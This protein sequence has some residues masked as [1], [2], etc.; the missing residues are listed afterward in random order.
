MKLEDLAQTELELR[1]E[2]L[3]VRREQAKPKTHTV[4]L[5]SGQTISFTVTLR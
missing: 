2:D 1:G 4:T 3:Q 5:A